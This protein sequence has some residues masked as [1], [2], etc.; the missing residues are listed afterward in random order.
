MN[1]AI[2]SSRLAPEVRAAVAIFLQNYKRGETP[3][4]IS[5]ALDAVR[6]VF[7]AMTLS[8]NDLTDAIAGEAVAVGLNIHFDGLGKPLARAAAAVERWEDEGGAVR[9]W[10]APTTG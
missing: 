3:F 5:E 1:I 2:E 9:Q 10:T 8:D 7:P 4:A 6:R